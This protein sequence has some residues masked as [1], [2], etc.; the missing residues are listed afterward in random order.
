MKFGLFYEMY[1]PPAD[2]AEEAR[3]VRQTVDQIVHADR[4]NWDYVWLTEHHFLGGFSHMSAPEVVFGAAAYATSHI[5]FGFGLALTPPQYNHPVRIAERVAMLDCLSGGRV[6][7]GSGRS[8]TPEELYG[9]GIDPETSRAQWEE[10]LEAVARL[11]AEEKVS[12]DGDY[13]KMPPRTT[14]PRPVQQ[15][16]PPLWVG[17]VGPGN[18]ERAAKRGLGML[19]FALKADPPSLEASIAAYKENITSAEPICGVVNNQTAGFVNGLCSYDRA[20]VRTLA[21]EKTVEHTFAGNQYMLNGWPDGAP[22]KSYAHVGAGETKM[23]FDAISADP[24][25]VADGL[26]EG[27]FVMAGTP[28]D[29]AKT[30][31]AFHQVG[32]DQVIIHMQMGNV[33]HERI[34]ESIE[35][36]GK[37]LIPRYR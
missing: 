9:F 13:L 15:P 30:L 34:M 25:A 22:T 4:H 2:R 26:L 35:L 7:L 3:V 20:A 1:V 11:L 31:D 27:G 19:F 32:V 24:K 37:E 5:R 10:G 23:F 17:G 28:E 16:H 6:D 33:P 18:A 8:T 12:F 14:Y 36:I 21:A 29:C